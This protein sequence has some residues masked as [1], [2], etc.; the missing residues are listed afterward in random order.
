MVLVHRYKV[1]LILGKKAAGKVFLWRLLIY[2]AKLV[3]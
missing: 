1:V 2:G 3:D